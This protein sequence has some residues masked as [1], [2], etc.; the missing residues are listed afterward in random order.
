MNAVERR[1]HPCGRR[2]DGPAGTSHVYT[3]DV[4]AGTPLGNDASVRLVRGDALIGAAA[5]VHDVTVVTRDLEDLEKF[6]D[7]DVLSPWT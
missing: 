3:S 1:R 6:D 7:L 4:P 2:P 5:L